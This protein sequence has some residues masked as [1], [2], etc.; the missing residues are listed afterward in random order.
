MRTVGTADIAT[1]DFNPCKNP[2]SIEYINT[3]KMQFCRH[4]IVDAIYAQLGRLRNVDTRL[5]DH[6]QHTFIEYRI[7]RQAT[8]VDFHI[9]K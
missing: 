6:C 2:D 8:V 9:F 4:K 5:P 7:A 1:R 3:C